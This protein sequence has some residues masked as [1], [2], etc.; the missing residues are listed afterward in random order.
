[1]RASSGRAA[2]E[3]R[4]LPYGRAVTPRYGT[5]KRCALSPAIRSRGLLQNPTGFFI[6][7]IRKNWMLSSSYVPG[8]K[9][10]TAVSRAQQERLSLQVQRETD[11]QQLQAHLDAEREQQ[12]QAHPT[13]QWQASKGLLKLHL[14]KVLNSMEWQALERRC[15][16]GRMQ[17]TEIATAATKAKAALCWDLFLGDLR[18][19]LL[20]V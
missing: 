9:K 4:P 3:A 1:M 15:V 10:P 19:Q 8:L 16:A 20:L 7:A 18:G 13:E 11:A 17:A 5:V 12:R 6:S 2:S 14:S